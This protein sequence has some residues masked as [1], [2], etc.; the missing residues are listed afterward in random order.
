METEVE[1]RD[2]NNPIN[3][4]LPPKTDFIYGSDPFR[5]VKLKDD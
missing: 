3:R 2:P 4:F 5:L 1:N